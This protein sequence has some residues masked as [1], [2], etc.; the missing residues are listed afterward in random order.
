MVDGYE[1]SFLYHKNRFYF[2]APFETKFNLDI[3][4]LNGQ[5]LATCKNLITTKK[6]QRVA[7]MSIKKSGIYIVK[8]TLSN[9]DYY[10]QRMRF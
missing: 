2:S 9:N 7:N 8:V 5:K 3:F 10:Y 6:Y 4:Q 1:I